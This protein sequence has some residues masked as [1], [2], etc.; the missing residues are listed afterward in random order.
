MGTQSI[1]QG[2]MVS[3]KVLFVCKSNVGRSQ[4]AETIFNNSYKRPVSMSAGLQP[5]E[6][7]GKE[8]SLAKNVVS[9]MNEIGF[10]IS[11]NVSK[12]ITKEMVDKSDKIIIMEKKHWPDYL[13][14]NPKVEYWEIPDAAGTDLL[15]H[16]KIRDQINIKVYN[17][18]KSIKK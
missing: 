15:F 9:C 8:I 7:E 10:D 14:N 12:K 17:L 6:W 16:R 11:K 3:M 5:G 13:K 4:M 2:G 1:L 18:I